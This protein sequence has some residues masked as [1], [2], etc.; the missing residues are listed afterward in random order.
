MVNRK[1][2]PQGHMWIVDTHKIH[3]RSAQT[4]W[5]LTYIQRT[6]NKEATLKS[7]CKFCLGNTNL[8]CTSQIQDIPLFCTIPFSANS[9]FCTFQIE[10]IP[11]WTH[12]PF[13]AHSIFGTLKVQHIT[14]C[15]NSIFVRLHFLQIP[16]LFSTPC[17]KHQQ[18]VSNMVIR[19]LFA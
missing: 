16:K 14:I 13:S 1:N 6:T 2:D 8:F 17:S 18:I 11:N 4:T 3:T 15:T 19:C 7:N 10:H 9:I 12:I 5:L